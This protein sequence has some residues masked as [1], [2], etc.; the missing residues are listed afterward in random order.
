MPNPRRNESQKGSRK[1]NA[2]PEAER[3][4]TECADMLKYVTNLMKKEKGSKISK[5]NISISNIWNL[6]PAGLR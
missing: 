5:L 3:M 6:Q 2:Q 4:N 1:E